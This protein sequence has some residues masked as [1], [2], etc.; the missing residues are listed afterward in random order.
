MVRP[1]LL[2]PPG[3]RWPI[4]HRIPL[5]KPSFPLSRESKNRPSEVGEGGVTATT[6]LRLG[7]YTKVSIARARELENMLP[8]EAPADG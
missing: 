8:K 6:A 7:G 5:Q 3:V 1:Y 4:S 2:P